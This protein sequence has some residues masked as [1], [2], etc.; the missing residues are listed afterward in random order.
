MKSKTV[1]IIGFILSL[2]CMFVYANAIEN[3][4]I[5]AVSM[6]FVVFFLPV[7]L[8][9]VIN[10]VYLRVLKTIENKIVRTI[11]SLVP[12][13]V[14]FALSFHEELT[15]PGLDANLIFVARVA[16]ISIGVTNLTW[17]AA[18]LRHK[19]PLLKVWI[20]FS[21]LLLSSFLTYC[22]KG[23]TDY[24]IY[25]SVINDNLAKG[26]ASVVIVTKTTEDKDIFEL[27]CFDT[28][29]E[30]DLFCRIPYDS[31]TLAHIRKFYQ[32][33]RTSRSLSDSFQ[34]DVKRYIVKR[35]SIRR[36]F[37]NVNRPRD[38]DAAWKRFYEMYPKSG[39]YFEFSSIFYL[40]D[41]QNVVVYYS[42]HRN[43]LNG[44]GAIAVLRQSGEG[45]STILECTLWNN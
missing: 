3:G 37:R 34:V 12:P 22:Q 32:T 18:T 44:K 45:W 10:A 8:I 41:K 25:S 35:A 21:F 17:I 5:N 9:V 20:P 30:G 33:P 43:G 29:S 16:V 11:L 27:G 24:L 7:V 1:V 14:F 15:L 19:A 36:L 6:Y 40:P 42:V 31:D 2:I 4:D 39:G 38:I 28:T 23:F 26:N 13:F